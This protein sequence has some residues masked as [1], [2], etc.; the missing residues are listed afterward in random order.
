[1]VT[2][3]AGFSGRVEEEKEDRGTRSDRS[4]KP[5]LGSK[6]YTDKPMFLEAVPG[7]VAY[8]ES[9]MILPFWRDGIGGSAMA[10][11]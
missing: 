9:Q 7:D 4:T 11:G 8:L 10:L 5:C 6:G 1:M 2:G 3:T